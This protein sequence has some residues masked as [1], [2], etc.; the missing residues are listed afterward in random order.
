M[1]LLTPIALGAVLSLAGSYLL[2][3]M[4]GPPWDLLAI[5]DFEVFGVTLF[6][7]WVIFVLVTVITWA[8]QK[9]FRSEADNVTGSLPPNF[10]KR[11]NESADTELCGRLTRHEAVSKIAAEMGRTSEA[12]RARARQLGVP[13]PRSM[14][15]WRPTVRQR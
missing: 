14:R 10:R 13:A 12:I 11:W 5:I 3:D 6:W 8:L 15:P 4:D 9:C 1:P 7:S 2:H